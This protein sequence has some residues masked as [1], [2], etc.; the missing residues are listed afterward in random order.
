MPLTTHCRGLSH[1]SI[2]S[3]ATYASETRVLEWQQKVFS[4][5]EIIEYRDNANCDT[6]LEHHYHKEVNNLLQKD[7]TGWRGDRRIFTYVDVD[8][9]VSEQEIAADVLTGPQSS[10]STFVTRRMAEVRQRHGTRGKRGGSSHGG[11]ASSFVHVNDVGSLAEFHLA[12]FVLPLKIGHQYCLCA[13]RLPEIAFNRYEVERVMCQ[14]CSTYITWSAFLHRCVS[15]E[16]MRSPRP[17]S[18]ST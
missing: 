12:M 5:A 2:A 8:D 7:R 3:Q 18:T 9:Y 10:T 11:T 14:W 6:P 4:W 13:L 17:L 15:K 1:R 16:S